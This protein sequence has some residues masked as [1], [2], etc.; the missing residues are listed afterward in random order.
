LLI[1]PTRDSDL[2]GSNLA[3]HEKASDVSNQTPGHGLTN[4]C[5][6]QVLVVQLENPPRDS[7]ICTHQIDDV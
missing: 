4:E 2:A 5:D 6:Q 1:A 7:P 3:L